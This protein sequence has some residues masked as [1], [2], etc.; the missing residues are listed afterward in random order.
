MHRH[1]QR[2]WP[3]ELELRQA[4]IGPRSRCR[5][6]SSAPRSARRPPWRRRSAVGH[7]GMR[8][9][10]A[11]PGHGRYSGRRVPGAW[12]HSPGIMAVVAC[13]RLGGELNDV[14]AASLREGTAGEAAEDKQGGQGREAES[15]FYSRW[16]GGSQG[17]RP[18]SR[19]GDAT[20]ASPL[21]RH[22]PMPMSPAQERHSY[23]PS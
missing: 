4:S 11:Q 22:R 17:F 9:T 8:S 3:R 23:R 5:R 18:R 19:C 15:H 1:D 12:P 6:W 10:P 21:G 7:S 2:D 20:S 16:L 14:G 13:L